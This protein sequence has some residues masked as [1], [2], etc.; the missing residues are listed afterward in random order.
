MVPVSSWLKYAVEWSRASF[1]VRE[2][3]I[4]CWG[5]L[6]P[7]TVCVVI[8]PAFISGP[9]PVSILFMITF[10]PHVVWLLLLLSLDLELVFY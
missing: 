4:A 3:D 8:I 1:S 2:H 6:S 10:V 5:V 7:S 9:A